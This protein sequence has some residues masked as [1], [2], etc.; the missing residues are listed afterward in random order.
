MTSVARMW[1][2]GN[3]CAPL[4]E[5]STELPQKIKY[6][7]AFG[8][9]NPTSGNLPKEIQNTNSKEYIH[10]YVHCSVIYNRQDLEADKYTSVDEQI[11][12]LWY[13]CTMEYYCAAK[14]E[15]TFTLCNTMDGP[16]EQ[17]A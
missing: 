16:G 7:P 15:G 13:L 6:V 2:K 14:K 5:S 8:P 17:Y 12:K 3:P 9:S 11:Q 4:V 10:S 1:S